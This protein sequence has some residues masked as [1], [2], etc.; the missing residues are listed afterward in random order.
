MLEYIKYSDE[1]VLFE[2]VFEPGF[3]PETLRNDVETTPVSGI[4]KSFV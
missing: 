2:T 4:P 3:E 1:N